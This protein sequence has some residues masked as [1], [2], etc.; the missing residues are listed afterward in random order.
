MRGGRY[1]EAFGREDV[2]QL[3]VPQSYEFLSKRLAVLTC[4]RMLDLVPKMRAQTIEAIKAANLSV[5]KLADLD[6]GEKLSFYVFNDSFEDVK[7]FDHYLTSFGFAGEWKVSEELEEVATRALDQCHDE[8]AARFDELTESL[9]SGNLWEKA[10]AACITAKM[11]MTIEGTIIEFI[12]TAYD[13]LEANF[14]SVL[15]KYERHDIAYEMIH[16]NAVAGL[17]GSSITNVVTRA[18]NRWA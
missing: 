7:S 2:L 16:I 14:R 3:Y 5:F 9:D 18:L 1:T 8:V 10:R 15:Q 12:N 11:A 13:R 4:R 6:L 17:L